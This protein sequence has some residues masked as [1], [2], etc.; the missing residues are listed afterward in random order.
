MGERKHQPEHLDTAVFGCRMHRINSL[1]CA[2]VL[3]APDH[4]GQTESL[5]DQFP[6]QNIVPV[7]ERLMQRLHLFPRTLLLVIPRWREG[8]DTDEGAA[9]ASATVLA[10]VL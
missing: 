8:H 2:T 7:F 6:C 3:R 9:T 1:Q 10:T 5:V 4:L